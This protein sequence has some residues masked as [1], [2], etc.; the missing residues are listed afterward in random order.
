MK[1]QLMRTGLRS[2]QEAQ[3]APLEEIVL[4]NGTAFRTAANREAVSYTP[5]FKPAIM[6]LMG[7][8]KR[9]ETE[10]MRVNRLIRRFSP[11]E[12]GANA[13]IAGEVLNNYL[14]ILYCRI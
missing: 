6:P 2:V 8:P 3:A 14:P 12:S 13:Y 11:P 1:E 10:E 7:V 9:G 4:R 5:V